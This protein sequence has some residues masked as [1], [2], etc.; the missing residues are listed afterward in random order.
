MDG[1]IA[2][3]KLYTPLEA[4][5][6]PLV[7]VAEGRVT[8]V[9]S[10][11]ALEIPKGARVLDLGDSILVPGFI[12]MHIHGGAGHDV[13]EPS[14]DALSAVEKLLHKHGVTT[15]FPTTVTAPVGLTLSALERLADAIEQAEHS[16]DLADRARPMGIHIEGPFISHKRPG[17]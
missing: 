15:Y 13:M 3:Q 10:R 5:E 4:I 12:D 7:F 8:Q 17:V 16:P 11:D 2:A 9:S 14:G 6:R 1:V